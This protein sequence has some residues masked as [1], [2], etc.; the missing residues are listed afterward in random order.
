GQVSFFANLNG[1]GTTTPNQGMFVGTAGGTPLP[2][3]LDL[4]GFAG[5]TQTFNGFFGQSGI[6][7]AGQ[8]AFGSGLSGNGTTTPNGG[9]F[10]GTGSATPSPSPIALDLGGFIGGTQTFTGFNSPAI[11]ATGQVAF[12]AIL[13]GNGTT[14]PGS[15]IFV[16]SA[17]STSQSVALQLGGFSGGS[18][19]FTGF[20][21]NLTINAAAQMA[22]FASLNGNGST[23]P[24]QGLFVGTAGGTPSPVALQL[25]TFSGGSQTFAFGFSSAEINAAGQVAFFGNLNG[26][27]T[28]TPNQGMFIGS[29]GTTPSA[30]ALELQPAPD[31]NGVFSFINQNNYSINREGTVAFASLL[32]GTAGGS[33]DNSGVFLGDARQVIQVAR[34]GQSLAGSTITS[35]QILLTPDLGGLSSLNDFGQFAYLAGLANGQSV[36]ALY[37]PSLHWRFSTS[38]SWDNNTNWTVGL[39]PGSL[40]QVLIDPAFGV[41]VTGT[42][43]NATINSL[44]IGALQSGLAVLQNNAG[45]NLTVANNITINGSGEVFQQSGTLLTNASLNNSGTVQVSTGGV[46]TTSTGFNNESS[47]TLSG[48]TI[49]GTVLNDFGSQMSGSGTIGGPLTNNGTLSLN[50]ALNVA[51]ALTNVGSVSV[52]TGS[53]LKP[54]AGMTNTGTMTLNGGAVGGAN[55]SNSPGGTIIVNGPGSAIFGSFGNAGGLL[56]VQPTGAITLANFSGGDSVGGQILIENGGSLNSTIPFTNTGSITLNGGAAQLGGGA[57]TNTGT[58][59][60]VGQVSS[61]VLNSG[62]VRADGG[63]LILSAAGNT[64]AASGQL[65]ATSGSTL[66]FTQGLAA[67]SGNIALAA[68]VFDNNNQLLTNN[69]SITG[70]GTLRTGGLTNSA[71]GAIALADVASSVIGTVSNSGHIN[72][73]NNTTTFY[74]AVTNNAGAAIKVTSGTSRFLS[75]FTNNGTFSSDPATN[76]FADLSLGPQGVLLGGPGDHFIVNGDFVSSSTQN[77]AWNTA[78]AMIE[79][80]GGGNHAFSLSGVDQGRNYT[81]FAENFSWGILQV[82]SGNSLTLEPIGSNSALYVSALVLADGSNQISEISGN[83]ADIYYDPG[84]PAN[85]YLAGQS[86]SLSGGGE[87]APVP[88]PAGWLPV[89]LAGILLASLRRQGTRALRDPKRSGIDR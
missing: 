74:N 8:V 46:I 83:G 28:T 87:I 58:V 79:F 85:A 40:H 23:T 25:G 30:I 80:T 38:G 10:V 78:Q 31:H 15:G 70:N 7:S 47:T 55:V 77:V 82:D 36:I 21:G 35:L 86:Y 56:H 53:T 52:S 73:T 39:Q 45:G 6:N 75:T 76:Y 13:N 43:L 72:I 33:T 71:G 3:A 42:A 89:A 11:N 9:I 63:Q 88:E 5:G 67:N 12:N 16:G 19:T 65:E 22:F 24:S 4:H 37:T 48:G 57:I 27:G 20:S 18:Q 50:G 17:G 51:G 26:N 62:T 64:N 41:T 66:F 1:N 59:S 34:T 14:T 2:V 68:S 60:G 54:L 84:N 29:P 61:Q 81:G 32:S 49:N 69:G 44:T